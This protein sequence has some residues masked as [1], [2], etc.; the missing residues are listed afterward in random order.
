LAHG[1]E[2]KPELRLEP[3]LEPRRVPALVPE[4]PQQQGLPL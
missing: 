3:V 1:Q 2:Q 4:L